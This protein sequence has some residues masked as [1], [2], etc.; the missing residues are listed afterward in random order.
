MLWFA[1]VGAIEKRNPKTRRTDCPFSRGLCYIQPSLC[2]N[3]GS[4]NTVFWLADF[5]FPRKECVRAK[6]ADFGFPRKEC[7]RAKMALHRS[8]LPFWLVVTHTAGET[9]PTDRSFLEPLIYLQRA[10]QVSGRATKSFVY[11]QR[12]VKFPEEPLNRSRNVGAGEHIRTWHNMAYTGRIG[13]SFRRHNR[14]L[15]E[16][17]TNFPSSRELDDRSKHEPKKRKQP[18][19]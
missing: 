10:V 15:R 13:F 2:T 5:G 19:I 4:Q 14:T 11:L 12:T 17:V 16:N 9:E 7:V 1:L 6:M 18:W 8:D 3:L